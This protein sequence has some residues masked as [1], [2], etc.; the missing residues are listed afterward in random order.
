V[1]IPTWFSLLRNRDQERLS[2]LSMIFAGLN[3]QVIRHRLQA[4]SFEAFA[5]R[6]W[7]FA[8]GRMYSAL[9]QD[10]DMRVEDASLRI[11]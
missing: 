10:N 2:I 7:Q 9:I 1:K 5:Q 11:S 4:V 6:F 3:G 8:D